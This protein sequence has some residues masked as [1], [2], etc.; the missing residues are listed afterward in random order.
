[1]KLTVV[2]VN[3]N[4]L[5]FLEQCLL[6]VQKAIGDIPTEVFVVDNASV[7][8]SVEMVREKFP[9]VKL[10]ANQD[11][12]GFSKA[13]NQAMRQATGE[14][15]LLL[16]P[17]T[18]VQ[19]DTFRSVIAFM[20]AHPLA[21]G[22]GVKMMDGNGHFL[23]ESKRGLPTPETS[24]YK[25][26]GLNAL[27]P[28][29]AKFNRY[30]LGNLSNDGTHE[31]EIL[32][33]AFMFM[34]KRTLDQVGLLDEA[35]FMYG[36]DIDLSW[37]IIQGGWKNYYF[38]DTRIIHYK[39]ES[40]KKG[41]LNYVFV[42]YN[43]MVIFARKHFSEQNA[44]IFSFFIHIA[45]WMRAG[46]AIMMR[47]FRNAIHPFVDGALTFGGLMVSK[48]LYAATLN[49]IYDDHLVVIAFL[50]YSSIWVVGTWIA[51]GYDKPL[52]P[53]RVIK[54]VVIGAA[55]I[56]IVYSLLPETMRFSRAL[57]LFGAAIALPV[58]VAT[59]VVFNLIRHGYSGLRPRVNRKIAVVGAEDE[60]Q[61]VRK[62]VAQAQLAVD[63]IIHVNTSTENN[64]IQLDEIVRVHDVDQVIF[65]ARDISSADIISAMSE[66]DTH[67]IEFKIAP[68]ESLYI[69]GSG[70]I[71]TSGDAFMLDI[72]SV[73]LP[74]NQRLKRA[75]D[76]VLSLCMIPLTP[77]LIFVQRNPIGFFQNVVG[78]LFGSKSWVGLYFS[79]TSSEFYK[80]P[81]L[82]K[83]VLSPRDMYPDNELNEENTQKLNI[84]YA[85]DYR[86]MNDLYI[87]GRNLRCLGRRV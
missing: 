23:P 42:F 18:V 5:Y 6:S 7:D 24:F 28:K 49:K 26:F 29:S 30:Y 50:I 14:Y 37:R 31:I 65:C 54:P 1:M 11:N 68:P 15:I 32:S 79:K 4:V 75:L 63:D 70:S 21:G 40:T 19:E 35:F 78:V 46:L 38:P 62:I 16:N 47:F 85:R 3:Y 20:D 76:V 83:G 10:I 8:R 2:I 55:L 48:N 17:D 59:R 41:S 25:I 73:S 56:L 77:V 52:K 22:L 86:V 81:R 87:V 53:L 74:L 43:A 33:G 45:I 67:Q 80:L 60:L 72:N 34:R 13:N 58:F 82:K 57:I 69:I 71:E 51:G 66:M 9:W 61:R 12:P 39:G 27:F 44:R 36:E 84:V 64:K